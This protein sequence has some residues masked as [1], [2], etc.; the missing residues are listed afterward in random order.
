MTLT[1]YF[2]ATTAAVI[3]AGLIV[4]RPV[5]TGSR[6]LLLK[7]SK[8]GEW[9]FPKGHQEKGETVLQTALRECAEECGLGLVAVEGHPLEATY[10]LPNGR[11]KVAVYFPAV[12]SQDAVQLSTE[13]D[14]FLWAGAEQ[15]MKLLPHA[16][17]VLLFRAYLH[18]RKQG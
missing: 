3:A 6:W 15:V 17:L 11:S 18:A 5:G 7:A 4:R 1:S 2:P 14:T 8:H 10:L 9:G 12:T 16:N 13:H